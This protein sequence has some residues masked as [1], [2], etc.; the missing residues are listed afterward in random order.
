MSTLAM[1]APFPSV[2]TFWATS[3]TL[4]YVRVVMSG[5][6]PSLTLFPCG[7]DKSVIRRHFPGEDFLGMTPIL[8]I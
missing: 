1:F 2:A 7:K 6:M 4:M 5:S 8:F 3:L